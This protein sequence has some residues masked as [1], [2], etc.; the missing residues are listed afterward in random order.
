MATISSQQEIEILNGTTTVDLIVIDLTDE[1][2][3]VDPTNEPKG[4]ETSGSSD[5]DVDSS[6][7]ELENPFPEVE[8]SEVETLKEPTV[9]LPQPSEEAEP[10]LKEVEPKTLK[11]KRDEEVQARALAEQQRD[12]ATQAQRAHGPPKPNAPGRPPA[13]ASWPRR[14]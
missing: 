14:R 7:D 13:R 9:P 8:V 1:P 6:H 4:S 3:V 2:K 5:S 11:R 12:E 10:T